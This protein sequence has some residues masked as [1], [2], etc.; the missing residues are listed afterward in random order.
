MSYMHDALTTTDFSVP[1]T[2]L[3]LALP[4]AFILG[5]LVLGLRSLVWRQLTERQIALQTQLVFLFATAIAVALLVVTLVALQPIHADLGSVWAPGYGLLSPSLIATPERALL[6]VFFMGITGLA[7][8]FSATYLHRESGFDRFFL[9]LWLLAAGLAMV[10]L[11]NRADLFFIGWEFVGL[12]SALLIGF[13]RNREQPVRAGLRAWVIYRVCDVALLLAFLLLHHAAHAFDWQAMF[14]TVP[15]LDPTLHAA[16]GLLLV[17]GAMGKS[18]QAPLTGWLPRAMEGPT[19]SSAL[20]Y[21]GVSVHLG[22]WL[23]LLVSP[24]VLSHPVPR[25]AIGVIGATTALAAGLTSRVRPDVKTAIGWSVASQVGVIW[26]E[27]ALGFT[28]LALVHML[29]HAVFRTGELLTSPNALHARLARDAGAGARLDH[30][31]PLPFPLPRAVERRLW[32]LA[33]NGFGMEGVLD[34]AVVRPVLSLARRLDR[35]ERLL[36]GSDRMAPAAAETAPTATG[37]SHG[38]V[39]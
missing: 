19:S 18:A 26:V 21:G 14:S 6:L 9:L 13:F 11:S 2:W 30:R 8:R 17:I 33:M 20:F 32:A 10:L 38:G 37:D 15:N 35:S 5:F 39:S 22:A 25:V 7:A 3:L 4:S 28:T 31:H 36:A 34:R 24:I 23:L 29:A 1:A 27:I 16:I 12:T